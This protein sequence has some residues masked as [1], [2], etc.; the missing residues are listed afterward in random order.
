MTVA[1]T[2]SDMDNFEVFVETEEDEM[3][4][5]NEPAFFT[6]PACTATFV[7]RLSLKRHMIYHDSDQKFTCSFCQ[8]IFFKKDKLADHI[9]SKHGGAKFS[10]QICHRNLSRRDH[11]IQ[12]YKNVHPDSVH[13]HS[14]VEKIKRDSID[15]PDTVS[16]CQLLSSSHVK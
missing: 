10:C 15:G 6:C 13:A 16:H 2:S 4:F 3:D 1:E 14:N 9:T 5:T 12:H 7:T 8:S 11:L